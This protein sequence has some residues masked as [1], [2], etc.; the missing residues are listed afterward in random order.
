MGVQELKKHFDAN[1][2][3]ALLSLTI[4]VTPSV[5]VPSFPDNDNTTDKTDLFVGNTDASGFFSLGKIAA[6]KRAEH[7]KDSMFFTNYVTD[8]IKER[9]LENIL[10]GKHTVYKAPHRRWYGTE[11]AASVADEEGNVLYSLY[12]DKPSEIASLTKVVSIYVV[13]DQLK[14]GNIFLEDEIKISRNASNQPVSTRKMYG[15]QPLF[16]EIYTVEKMIEAAWNVS[17][18]IGTTALAEYVGDGS[19]KEFV[20]MMNQSVEEKGI[21]NAEFYNPTGLNTRKKKWNICPPSGVATIIN[22]LVNDFPEYIDLISMST[23]QKPGRKKAVKHPAAYPLKDHIDNHY[24]NKTGYYSN[25]GYWH[26]FVRGANTDQYQNS[27]KYAAAF[28]G[29]SSD[30]RKKLTDIFNEGLNEMMR[31]KTGPVIS[32]ATQPIQPLPHT[33]IKPILLDTSL[34]KSVQQSY[35]RK[36]KKSVLEFLGI[37]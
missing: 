16:G 27:L 6:E 14:K 21:K 30:Q 19:V 35:N 37:Q 24:A 9:G 1:L 5:F 13:F 15:S 7:V 3:T 18:N 12:G 25:T 11:P 20:A 4:L 22:A 29:V 32:L 28:G 8:K 33:P 31:R 36:K 23:Y 2:K 34:V 26:S 17:S 10:D